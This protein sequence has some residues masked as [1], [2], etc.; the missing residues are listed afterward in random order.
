M[1]NSPLL[2]PVP[3]PRA[4]Q[5]RAWWRAPASSTALAYAAYAAAKQQAAP[6]LLIASDNHSA[7]QLEADLRVLT[8]ADA[9]VPV[10]GFPDWETLPYD[11]FSPHPEIV[12][13]RLATLAALPELK[14]GIVVVSAATL[15]Q[16]LAPHQHILGNRFNVHIGQRMDMDAE[17]RRL[18]TAGYRHVPQVYDPGDFAVRGGLL[19]IFPMGADT[20]FRVELLDDEIDSIRTFDTESQRSLEKIDSIALLPGR[21]VPMDET[22]IQHALD[23][24]TSRFDIDTRRSA[25]VQ[26]LKAGLAPA[27]V[28]YYLPLFFPTKRGATTSTQTLFDYLPSSLLPCVCEGAMEALDSTWQQIHHRYEQ[29]RH[30][31]ERPLLPPSELWLAPDALRERLNQGDRI[32]I[33]GRQHPRHAD[34]HPLSV[35]SAPNLPLTPKDGHPS[36]ALAD[37]LRHYPGRVLIA[38][39]SAGRREA[40]LEVLQASE[41][42]PD[43][44]ADWSGF[45]GCLT[46]GRGGQ[47]ESLPDTRLVGLSPDTRSETSGEAR[48]ICKHIGV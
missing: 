33:C 9:T 39:D 24:L 20:P 10:L 16:R 4:G 5:H 15:M 43:V 11:R 28:E 18:E 23:A 25:L 1:P 2:F 41:L 7:H 34:A 12:S 22:H 36:T 27:G 47:P 29:L 42:H 17:K 44:L 30:D 35:Q 3:L 37:F 32:E 6:L 19:D 46:A 48:P 45:A 13:Q 8:Q 40:L 31:V 21:E 14:Q 38:A 26:D